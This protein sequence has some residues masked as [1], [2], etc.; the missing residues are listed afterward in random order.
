VTAT[1]GPT[2]RTEPPVTLTSAPFWDATRDGRYLLQF[3]VDCG[4]P[5]SYPR[6]FCP[7]CGSFSLEWRPASGRGTVHSFTVDHKG[8]PAIGGGTPFVIAL[9]DLDEGARVMTNVVG[10]PPDAVS[11]GL[12]VRVT[13][14]PLSD[15]RQL[16]LFTPT[17]EVTR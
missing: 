9:V 5:V 6:E 11:V 16:P 8:H 17:E 4:L 7:H 2:G 14:E 3:C 15:G 12:A 10:C 13:W 1:G